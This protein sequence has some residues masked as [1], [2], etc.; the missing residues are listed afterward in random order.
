[1]TR[2]LVK[3]VGLLVAAS[4]LFAAVPSV[5]AAPAASEPSSAAVQTTAQSTAQSDTRSTT[6][7]TAQSTARAASDFTAYM[8]DEMKLDYPADVSSLI[9]G[10]NTDTWSRVVWKGDLVNGKVVVVNTSYSE[11]KSFTVT[12]SDFTDGNGHT[13]PASMIEPRWVKEMSGHTGKAGDPQTP[14][15]QFP[16]LIHETGSHTLN[17][18]KAAF[19]WLTITIP[20]DATAGTYT[21]KVTVSDGTNSTD[22]AMSF[23]VLDLATPSVDDYTDLEIWQHPFA[24]AAY[25][26]ISASKYMSDEHLE[27]MRGSMEEYASM[28]GHTAVANMVDEP[29]NHQ[30]YSEDQGMV[31]ITKNRDGTWSFDYTMYDKWIKFMIDT[32]VVNPTEGI[33][34]ISA[35]SIVPWE[36]RVA[37]TDESTGK[38]V[39][40]TFDVGSTE[41]TSF[42][43]AYLTDFAKHSQTNGWLDI[44]Y[45]ALDE[46]EVSDLTAAVNLI[47]TIKLDDSSKRAF[48]ISSALNS[49]AASDYDLSDRIDYVSVRQLNNSIYTTRTLADHRTS[50]GLLTSFYTCTGDNPSN[51]A[52][53]DPGENY[54]QMWR[55]LATHTDGFMRWAWDNWVEDPYTSIDFTSSGSVVGKWEPGDGWFIYP[56]EKDSSQRVDD[57]RGF[58]Y[59]PKYMMLK[60]GLQDVAK[61]RWLAEKSTDAS[62]KLSALVAGMTDNPDAITQSRS[63]LAG[64]DEIA[65]A[66]VGTGSGGS[67]GSE[68]NVSV[69]SSKC[70]S[71]TEAAGLPDLC[72]LT[73]DGFDT[74]KAKSGQKLNVDLGDGLTLQGTV[75]YA[76]ADTSK[77]RTLEAHTAPT[78][79]DGSAFGNIGYTGFGEAKVALYQPSTGSTNNVIGLASHT[80]TLS[81]L[82]V[83]KDGEAVDSGSWSLIMTDA[84]STAKGGTADNTAESLTYASNTGVRQFASLPEKEGQS[85]CAE[86]P[87]LSARNAFADTVTCTGSG[88]DEGGSASNPTQ[89]IR[90]YTTPSPTTAS[91]TIGNQVDGG[92][93]GIAFAVQLNKAEVSLTVSGDLVDSDDSFVLTMSDG[94]TTASDSDSQTFALE[95]RHALAYAMPLS[96]GGSTGGSVTFKLSAGEN[97]DLSKYTITESCEGDSTNRQCQG[98]ADS[99][100]GSIG[101]ID[102]DAISDTGTAIAVA[103]TVARWHFTIEPAPQVETIGRLPGTGGRPNM[104]TALAYCGLVLAGAGLVWR[105]KQ[106]WDESRA[107]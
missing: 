88:T 60:Q 15:V 68:D 26:G 85:L 72:W 73:W 74:T 97:T 43:T 17:A 61:A 93:Q 45:I 12:P 37:Y 3:L 55:I 59:T 13:L 105:L 40:L 106:R 65:E 2:N 104:A 32:G 23:E 51:F 91:V 42:W 100:N 98:S 52:T 102:P 103:G 83:T 5:S 11:S 28:G 76:D 1:M 107:E 25:Y 84:E 29:W 6:Q 8:G 67:G 54:W 44:T 36:N 57:G 79:P 48:H 16:D 81:D 62:T 20:T 89:G 27:L 66:Y 101:I 14:E 94:T 19:S 33:G 30:S 56:L 4:A 92:N 10:A 18:R 80:L 21:G 87:D 49:Q 9:S 24:T 63:M 71:A 96:D 64:L 47:D 90:M 7:T 31:E 38:E 95:G 58:Y 75:T 70:V 39:R 77:P 34:R 46:R 69:A 86:W 50:L 22:L 82:A 35:Y 99:G 78:W 53:D 41:W